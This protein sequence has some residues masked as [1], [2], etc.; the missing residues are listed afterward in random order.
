MLPVVLNGH[1]TCSLTVREGNNI[2]DVS[3]QSAE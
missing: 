1:E 3:E 2:D